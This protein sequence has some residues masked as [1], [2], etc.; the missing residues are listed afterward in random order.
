MVVGTSP[1]SFAVS[2]SGSETQVC[3]S[4]L[5]VDSDGDGPLRRELMACGPDSDGDVLAM[6][7][8]QD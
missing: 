8:E 2:D 5:L 4:E 7:L 1:L 6:S 3:P